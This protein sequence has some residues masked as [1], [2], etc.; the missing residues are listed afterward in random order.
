MLPNTN[1]MIF[2]KRPNYRRSK[3]SG[4]QEEERREGMNSWNIGNLSATDIILQDTVMA[5]T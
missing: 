3:I 2:W 4:F 1:Y 5:D